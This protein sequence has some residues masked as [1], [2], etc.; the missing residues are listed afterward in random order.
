MNILQVVKIDSGEL[1]KSAHYTNVF[2]DMRAYGCLK[3]PMFIVSDVEKILKIK[4]SRLNNS[5]LYIPGIHTRRITIN[6]VK[7]PTTVQALTEDG[8][9]K[10]LF[11]SNTPDALK[12]QLFVSAVLRQLRIRGVVTV[13]SANEEYEKKI[14]QITND[15]KEEKEMAQTALGKMYERVLTEKH[16]SNQWEMDAMRSMNDNLKLK[17]TLA[18]Y[19][20]KDEYELHN[21]LESFIKKYCKPVY[22]YLNAMPKKIK[23]EYDEYSLDFPLD[24]SDFGLY[25]LTLKQSSSK[26]KILSTT[27]YMHTSNT[28]KSLQ[29]Q[30][31][32]S[33]EYSTA[34]QFYTTL[35]NIKTIFNNDLYKC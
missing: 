22:I 29:E 5:M 19:K 14:H 21:I 35:D 7:G 20:Q 24:D 11:A 16:K 17:G 1:S 13:D 4:F 2:K 26:T 12:F 10:A 8:L 25:S 31:T 30:I 23:D 33:C 28:L 15:L 27:L 6:S 32:P 9:L 18:A 3:Y 34:T